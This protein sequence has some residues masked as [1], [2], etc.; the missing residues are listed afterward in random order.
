[1]KS[2]S[3]RKEWDRLWSLYEQETARE[4]LHTTNPVELWERLQA[5]RDFKQWAEGLENEQA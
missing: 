1:M 5:G 3:D 2:E 4:F